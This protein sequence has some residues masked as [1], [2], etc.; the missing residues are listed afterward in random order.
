M[1]TASKL[2]W[3]IKGEGREGER[4]RRKRNEER[5]KNQEDKENQRVCMAKTTELCRN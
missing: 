5:E 2:D 3:A 4:K 1:N